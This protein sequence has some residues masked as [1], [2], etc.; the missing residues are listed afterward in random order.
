MVPGGEWDQFMAVLRQPLPSTFR[1]TGTPH[2]A[3]AVREC[4]QHRFFRQL[5]E[6]VQR[7]V[8]GEGEELSP[9]TPLPWSDVYTSIIVQHLY[10]LHTGLYTLFC[11]IILLASGSEPT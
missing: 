10:V 8:E 7:G 5:T 2:L 11:T 9:P 6:A 1:I 3:A 4:L